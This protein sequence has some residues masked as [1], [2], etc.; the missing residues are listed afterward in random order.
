M[1]DEKDV[2]IVPSSPNV[3]SASQFSRISA[4]Q[5]QAASGWGNKGI[6]WIG[7][8]I[9]KSYARHRREEREARE[10]AK[11][12]VHITPS[13]HVR[14]NYAGHQGTITV[15]NQNGKAQWFKFPSVTMPEMDRLMDLAFN[16]LG[17]TSGYTANVHWMK[18]RMEFRNN[19][20]RPVNFEVYQLTAKQDIPLNAYSLLSGGMTYYV[21]GW[22]LMSDNSNFIVPTDPASV[23]DQISWDDK[24][25][26][27]YDFVNVRELFNIKLQDVRR[28]NPGDTV[29]YNHGLN[30][31]QLETL[32]EPINGSAVTYTSTYYHMQ[33]AGPVY[34][35]KMYGD[36]V[37][38]ETD[39]VVQIVNS[40]RVGVDYIHHREFCYADALSLEEVWQRQANNTLA[41][42]LTAAAHQMLP[43]DEKMFY[44]GDAPVEAAPEA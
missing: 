24:F 43:A 40:S 15:N 21:S 3:P 11:S 9:G 5:S 29:Q 18:G 42:D 27:I 7:P 8:K 39:G 23:L 14:F 44:S 2:V 16:T 35:V 25:N 17:V 34:I 33:K 36:I 30:H 4:V 22:D 32:Q 19:T 1:E 6:K 31:F 20:N 28:L 37:H 12:G 13:R 41:M 10:L 38:S 26:S